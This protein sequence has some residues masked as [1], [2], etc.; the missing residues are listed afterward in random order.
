MET[1]QELISNFTVMNKTDPIVTKV[2]QGLD[3]DQGFWV[4]DFNHVRECLNLWKN[5]MPNV[6]MH[7]A[8]K[9]NDE[10]TLL[11][12]LAKAGAGFDCASKVEI[13]KILDLHVDPS[14]IVFSHPLKNVESLR[15]AKTHQV[16]KLVFDSTEELEKIMKY[17]PESNV[18][19]RVKP[20]FSN[21]K[22]QLSNKFGADE[23][24]VE[25][26]LNLVKSLNAN[27]IG[28]SFHVGSLCDDISSFQYALKYIKELKDLAELKG[29]NVKFIDI[30]GGF[31]SPHT[32][33]KNPFS[34]IG[35][36]IEA[37][38]K[39]EFGDDKIEF[40]GEPG[41]FIAT[42]YLDLHLPVIGKKVQKDE[43]GDPVQMIFIPD[44]IYGSFNA[45]Q[46]D[47]AKPHFQ[48]YAISKESKKLKRRLMKTSLWGQ[49][50]DS[51]DEIYNN[52]YWPII[53]VGDLLTVRN[54]GAYTYSP[55]S[56]FNG[57]KQHQV[58]P[59]HQ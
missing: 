28:F 21:A 44:G 15:F 55:T 4:A 59:I 10:P 2:R 34:V 29:L 50:C 16:K 22:I 39:E 5:H 43:N 38:I 32:P 25:P 7:Y 46:Y 27:F 40:V 57:F 48:I 12:F 20:R 3:D 45:I 36:S 58:I 17:Y 24:D 52:L 54:F 42:E 8:I 14:K 33:A 1:T 53:E 18:Y 23:E 56:F 11:S 26:L 6:H 47:H 41:R 13:E 37:T 9:C 30:G 51:M 35:D 19:L 31:Y 49:T